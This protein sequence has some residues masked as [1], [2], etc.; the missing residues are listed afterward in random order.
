VIIVALIALFFF[1]NRDRQHEKQAEI[2]LARG[3]PERVQPFAK[4]V[5]ARACNMLDWIDHLELKPGEALPA[6]LILSDGRAPWELPPDLDGILAPIESEL[7]RSGQSETLIA[8]ERLSALRSAAKA[9]NASAAD[10]LTAQ[11]AADSGRAGTAKSK[12]EAARKEARHAVS[13]A[14]EAME[15]LPERPILEGGPAIMMSAE[16]PCA[17]L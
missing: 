9:L 10:L 16:D 13:R 17:A 1:G 15:P 14:E 3:V 12:F 8:H 4:D 6:A 2:Q 11:I 5:M 7:G